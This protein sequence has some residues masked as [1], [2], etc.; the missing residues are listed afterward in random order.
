MELR[1]DRG[2]QHE[3]IEAKAKWFAALSVEE[4]LS[5][6]S[7]FYELAVALNPKLREGT[8]DHRPGAVVRVLS[9]RRD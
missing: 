7:A 4:R 6:M 3:S 5:Q 9:L 8:D 2:F 1:L